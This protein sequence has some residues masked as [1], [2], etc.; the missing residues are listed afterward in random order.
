MNVLV[1]LLFTV[2]VVVV[3]A[4]TMHCL[5]AFRS[6]TASLRRCDLR[7]T[8]PRGVEVAAP[9]PPPPPVLLVGD[10]APG[11]PGAAVPVGVGVRVNA[12]PSVTVAVGQLAPTHG[13]DVDVGVFVGPAV[14]VGAGVLVGSGVFVGAEAVPQIVLMAAC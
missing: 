14:F 2:V 1:L 8:S 4:L 9:G 13:V 12:G 7:R 3:L 5:I 10:P 6:P 11:V